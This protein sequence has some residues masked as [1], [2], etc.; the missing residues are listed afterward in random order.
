M[1][2]VQEI[3]LDAWISAVVEYCNV[4]EIAIN[5]PQLFDTE[6]NA[7]GVSL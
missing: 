2:T 4:E 6:L 7:E 3:S 5:A 1:I